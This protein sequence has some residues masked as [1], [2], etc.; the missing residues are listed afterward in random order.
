MKYIKKI[1]PKKF[2]RFRSLSV[3]LYKDLNVI[4]GE[5]ESGK[6]TILSAINCVLGGNRKKIETIGIDRLINTQAIKEFLLSDKN[7]EDLPKLSVELYLNE[8]NNIDLNGKNNSDDIEC[9]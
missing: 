6:S 9:D 3:P 5:N 4:V 8:Q 1:K 7:Y 2:K